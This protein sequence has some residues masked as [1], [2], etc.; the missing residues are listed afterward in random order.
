[1]HKKLQNHSR[2]NFPLAHIKSPLCINIV[3]KTFHY[4]WIQHLN[5]TGSLI[6]LL[7]ATLLLT[8]LSALMCNSKIPKINETSNRK[9][10][11]ESDINHSSSVRRLS[12]VP[13]KQCIHIYFERRKWILVNSKERVTGASKPDLV[14]QV[15]NSRTLTNRDG[16][17]FLLK[18][19]HISTVYSVHQT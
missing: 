6:N 2:Q 12:C 15:A 9:V 18:I 11:K 10:R 16:H 1:M 13:W 4:Q 8:R 7:L 17:S 19:A 14:A 5:H 3:T